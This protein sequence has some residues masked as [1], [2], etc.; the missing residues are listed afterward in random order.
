MSRRKRGTLALLPKL[1]LL[2]TESS[3]EFDHI[4][5]AIYQ[6]LKPSGAIKQLYTA[7]IIELSWEIQ[8]LRRCKAGIVNLTFRPALKTFL[9]QLLRQPGQ[10]DYEVVGEADDL[11]QRW[12]TDQA[13]KKQVVELLRRFRLDEFAIEAEAIREPRASDSLTGCWRRWSRAVTRRSVA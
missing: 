4:A 12:F 11:A 10:E 9:K 13:A 1:P 3:D 5:D 2:I 6:E 7:D 8:C